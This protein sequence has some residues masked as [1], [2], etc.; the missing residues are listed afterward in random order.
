VIADLHRMQL[1]ISVSESDI[2]SVHV[3]QPATVTVDALPNE[4]FAARVTSISV[5]PT[6]SSGVVSYDVTLQL[7]QTSS[8]GAGMSASATIVTAQ[9]AGAVTVEN[10]AISSR[11]ANSTVTVDH[12]GKMVVTPVITG[13]AGTN[14]TQ[15]VSGLQPGQEVAIPITTRLATAGSTGTGGTLGGGAGLGGGGGGFLG[16]GGGI[17]RFLRGGG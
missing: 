11:G 12:N 14:A 2:G 5:L 1:V 4:E 13:L 16:G 6:S 10:A 7:T 3:G 17:G 15:I 9:A 8:H